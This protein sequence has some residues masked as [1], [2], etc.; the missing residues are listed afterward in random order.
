MRRFI[1]C[2]ADQSFDT[3]LT[4]KIFKPASWFIILLLITKIMITS[5]EISCTTPPLSM[6]SSHGQNNCTHKT[7]HGYSSRPRTKSCQP[8]IV[9]AN[10]NEDVFVHG[11][12]R[13]PFNVCS[14]TVRG[15]S[16]L[17]FLLDSRHQ[18]G[19]S[20]TKETN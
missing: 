17:V 13:G 1:Y 9:T 19:A 15:C 11:T 14:H 3:Y 18:S 16:I 7:I 20:G 12:W 2:H 10:H 8:K 4:K 6:Q 5:V